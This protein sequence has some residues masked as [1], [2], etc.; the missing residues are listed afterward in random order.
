[1]QTLRYDCYHD[2]DIKAFLCTKCRLTLSSKQQ[3]Q[4]PLF[5]TVHSPLDI[6][7]CSRISKK[8]TICLWREN[9]YDVKL[10][11]LLVF[12]G[13]P[14]IARFLPDRVI[15][16]ATEDGS[17]HVWNL[18]SSKIIGSSEKISSFTLLAEAV[19]PTLSTGWDISSLG[20]KHVHMS[21]IVGLEIVPDNSQADALLSQLI[22]IDVQGEVIV[23]YV[24]IVLCIIREW[25]AE[26]LNNFL[27]HCQL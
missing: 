5:I 23:W 4:G 20:S 22:S 6:E 2:T 11:L 19:K 14:T 10:C 27:S 9:A 7:S 26:I 12:Q 24:F 15:I 13:R 16:C 1:M 3:T 8:G 18:S 17:M 25:T 21:P